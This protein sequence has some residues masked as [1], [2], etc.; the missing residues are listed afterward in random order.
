MHPLQACNIR[1]RTSEARARLDLGRRV[2]Q[3]PRRA[4]MHAL[5]CAPNDIMF[6]ALKRLGRRASYA[7]QLSMH[8]RRRCYRSGSL[9]P[10]L[11][12]TTIL[13]MEGAIASSPSSSDAPGV[14][15]MDDPRLSRAV[16][17]LDVCPTR[18]WEEWGATEP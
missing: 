14:M 7:W 10:D 16:T 13:C 15:D 1:I 11:E 3:R 18:G 9:L 17:W 2:R 12:P 5:A 6:G 8:D 4:C